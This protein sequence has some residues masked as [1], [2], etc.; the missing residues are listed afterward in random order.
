MSRLYV[1][2]SIDGL[3]PEHDLRRAPATYDRILKN[4]A[5]QRVTIH[6]TVTGQMMKRPG[7]L[8]EFLEFWT[9]RPEIKKVWFSL[10]TPQVGDQI[11]EILTPEERMR[12]IADMKQLRKQYPKLDMPQAVIEQFASPPRRPQDC[13]FALTTHTLSADLRTTVSPC[14]FGGNPDCTSC[15]CIA[16]MGLASIASHKLGGILSVGAIFKGSIKIGQN[17]AK[18]RSKVRAKQQPQDAFTILQGNEEQSGNHNQT[19]I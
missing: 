16:S 15:G 5:G 12:A 17:R 2:V 7:Y 11:P 19:R 13:V 18:S 6:C 14:Q 9:P 8:A 3:Q 10:F 4:I 1:V